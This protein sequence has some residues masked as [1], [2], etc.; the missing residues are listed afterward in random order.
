[1]N[2]RLESRRSI[3][4]T[5]A[6][7]LLFILNFGACADQTGDTL[8][9]KIHGT[10][11][12]I[13]CVINNDKTI[14]IEF[15]NVGVN[16][17]D[18]VNYK[19]PI[20]YTLECEDRDETASLHMTLRGVQASYNTGAVNTNI[21]GLGIE[22]L[23]NGSPV[24]INKSFVIDFNSPPRLEAVPVSSG[25]TLSEGAFSATATLLAEYE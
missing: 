1:M 12:R 13:P 25:A 4:K 18:G 22:I 24:T 16:K 19:Q 20:D 9:V 6:L 2:A 23:Q 15:G 17:V 11:K 14:A 8:N 3:K 21:P 5:G 10:L 7:L